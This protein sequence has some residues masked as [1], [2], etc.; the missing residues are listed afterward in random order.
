MKYHFRIHKEDDGFWAQ[1][2]ELIGCITQADSREELD[3]NMQEALNLFIEEPDSSQDVA[4]LPDESIAPDFNIVEVSLDPAIAFSFL[5][6]YYRIK[7]GMTQT[8]VAKKMGFHT[9]Y[10]Y[11]RLEAGK[12]NPSLRMLARIK[13]VFPEFS[14]DFALA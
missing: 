10:S 13:E 12:C 9:L 2:I 7:L 8:E 14:I 1:C 3:S 6:R 5:M 11:Q 4:N